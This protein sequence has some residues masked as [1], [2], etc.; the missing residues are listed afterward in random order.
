MTPARFKKFAAFVLAYTIAVIVW[1]AYVRASGSGAGCGSH[2]P[3]C[4]GQVLPVATRIQTWIEFSHRLTSGLTILFTI[5]LAVLSMKAFPKGHRIRKASWIAVAFVF[6]EAIIG[7]ALVLLKLVEQDQSKLRAISIMLHYSNTLLL[8]GALTVTHL[9]EGYKSLRQIKG[10]LGFALGF[11]VLGTIGA[12]TALG[13]TLFPA[14]S[15]SQGMGQDFLAGSHFL[16]KLRAIHPLFALVYGGAL[17]AWVSKHMGLTGEPQA[18]R[19][20][21]FLCGW[22]ITNWLLGLLNLVLLA[23]AVLQLAHL[24]VANL[25]WVALLRYLAC[26]RAPDTILQSI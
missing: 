10:S 6:S 25:I 22:V 19:A 15:L 21:K 18:V 11:M 8:V 4:N 3:L 2:W 16:V 23:P 26:S 24:F 13:D 17:M 5:C 20:G 7:A 12:I 1:G 14:Q 9:G